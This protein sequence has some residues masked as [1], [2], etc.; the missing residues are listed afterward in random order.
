MEMK[1]KAHMIALFFEPTNT[2]A[3]HAFQGMVTE[4][5]VFDFQGAARTAGER[6]SLLLL[7]S[8]PRKYPTLQFTVSELIT[9]GD[10][11]I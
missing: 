5:V 6:H 1:A 9:G 11:F 4:Q 10:P 8:L 2:R 7:K 3:Y